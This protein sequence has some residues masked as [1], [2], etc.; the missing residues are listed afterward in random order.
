M[1]TEIVSKVGSGTQ[2]FRQDNFEKNHRPGMAVHVVNWEDVNAVQEIRT[3]GLDIVE[4]ATILPS[5]APALFGRRVMAIFNNDSTNAVFVGPA[6]V[7]ETNGYPV[8]AGTEKAFA[9]AS[10]L[11]IFVVAGAGNAVNIRIMEIA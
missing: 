10:N 1:A 11:D 4:A 9:L 2:Q 7:T 5:G 3:S 6:G 8:S